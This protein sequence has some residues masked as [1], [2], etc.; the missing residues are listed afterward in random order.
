MKSR[1]SRPAPSH[2]SASAPRFAS[3][4]ARIGNA[5]RAEPRDAARGTGTSV[6]PRFGATSS[7]P[8]AVDQ[9]RAG[10]RRRRRRAGR[11]AARRLERV[12][13]QPP[14]GRRA[15]RR[16]RGRGCRRRPASA[17]RS[18]PREVAARTARKS[19]PI[20][21]PRPTTRPPARARPG[22]AGRPTVP[23]SSHLGL[24]HE[25]ELD[26]L[27][28][29]ARDGRLVEPG[30]LRD[31]R[32]RARPALGDVAQHHAEVVPP[33]RALVG[34]RAA[35]ML[36]LHGRTLTA[37]RRQAADSL[38]QRCSSTRS[39]TR[40]ASWALASS[41]VSAWA[42]HASRSSR[43]G[44]GTRARSP[45]RRRTGAD[46]GPGPGRASAGSGPRLQGFHGSARSRRST[47]QAAREAPS[48]HGRPIGGGRV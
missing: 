35:G 24:A 33:H 10:R 2:S 22:S 44:S 7:R 36:A 39:A 11:C 6:Q 45:P 1:S 34:G 25:P 48:L 28:D 27:A 26:Q 40:S 17:W 23:R 19:T 13:G 21:S 43:R 47:G 3:F 38:A 42:S 14:R 9:S 4:S 16:P 32:A 8:L 12:A 31:R 5:G 18:A 29:Q 15:P 30:L 37:R 41:T 20:S 46:P